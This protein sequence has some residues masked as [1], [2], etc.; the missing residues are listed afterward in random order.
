MKDAKNNL[1]AS[2]SLAPAIYSTNQAENGASVDLLG[3]DGAIAVFTAGT[4]T[5]GTYVPKLQ[6]SE[7]DAT[8]SDV[9]SADMEGSLVSMTANSIQRVGYKGEKRY[10]RPVVTVSSATSG[11]ALCAMMIRSIPHLAPVA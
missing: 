8:W 9:A 2:K 4:L 7:D 1:S 5:D 6:E 11:G 10:L 3:F